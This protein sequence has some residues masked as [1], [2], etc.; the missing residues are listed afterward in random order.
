MEK[1]GLLETCIQQLN[2]NIGSADGGS[3]VP[4]I[5]LTKKG[6]GSRSS[7]K[8]LD[9][10]L[11]GIQKSIE[12]A[13]RTASES[14]AASAATMAKQF[15]KKLQFEKEQVQYQRVESLK[16]KIDSLQ[17]EQLEAETKAAEIRYGERPN[18]QLANFYMSKATKF[19]GRSEEYREEIRQLEKISGGPATQSA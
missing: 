16:R 15:D 4:D 13:A 19:Q 9:S 14:A 11:L 8:T 1:E 5:V 3:S 17:K 18:E 10:S 12:M 2:E 7:A 6:G